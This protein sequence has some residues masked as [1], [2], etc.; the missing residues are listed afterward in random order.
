MKSQKKS[1]YAKLGGFLKSARTKLYEDTGQWFTPKDIARQL[2]VSTSFVYQVEQGNKKPKDSQFGIWA[3][4][5]G[6][7]H[8]DMW[9]CVDRVPMDLVAGFKQEAQPTADE[10]FSK[11]TA[12]ERSELVPFMEFARWKIAHK[13]TNSKL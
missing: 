3:S 12:E 8:V 2:S 4:V 11:M 6:V 10:L 1:R 7:N 13:V 5:Y 9:K